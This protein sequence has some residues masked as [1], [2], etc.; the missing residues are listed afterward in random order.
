[1]IQNQ[2]G[3][4][5]VVG[6]PVRNQ[7]P[8]VKS[9]LISL[10]KYRSPDTRILIVDDA[11]TIECREFLK[12]FTAGTPRTDLICNSQQKGFPYNCNEIIYNSSADT[13]CLLNSDTLVAGEWDRFIL[14]IMYSNDSIGLAGPSTSFT[15]T[16]QSLPG[17]QTLRMAQNEETVNHIA[18]LV[19][20]R[21]KNQYQDLPRLGGF[22]FFFKRELIRR[23]GYFDERFSPGC[24]E[25]DDFTS[26]AR[27]SGYRAM[28]VKY[29]YVHHFGHCSF[30]AE[31]GKASAQLWAKNKLIFEIKQLLP[32]IG[33]IVHTRGAGCLINR[34]EGPRRE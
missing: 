6:V 17:L 4:H 32:H 25:E 19:F 9:C 2:P 8:F 30:T 28:W 21:Y 31:M 22:C 26:R 5:L 12:E 27:K 15:H 18:G 29:A 24:G 20:Q 1:M 16:P 34:R 11:S 13:I 3:E 7:L 23:I 14:E 10:A 33:E